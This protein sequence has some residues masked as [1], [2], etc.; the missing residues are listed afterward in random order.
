MT[1][2]PEIEIS[3]EAGTLLLDGADQ[4][5]DLPSLCAWDER[6]RRWRAP[7][8]AYRDLVEELI[9]RKLPHKDLAR[10]YLQFDFRST[11]VVEPRPYQ[12]EALASWKAAGRRGVVILP[13]GAGKSLLAQMAIEL[14][15]R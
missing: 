2:T 11:L 14:T 12:Q 5:A 15:G 8:L 4:T 9:R 13:T 1:S 3:F 10:Q 6:V 7:A